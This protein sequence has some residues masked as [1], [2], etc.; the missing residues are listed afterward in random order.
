VP[1]AFVVLEPAAASRAV[2]EPAD[3][4]RLKADIIAFV[5][6][7]KV[8]YKH[9]AGGVEFIDAVPKTPSGKLVRRILRDKATGLRPKSQESLVMKP[10][11]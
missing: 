1:L 9:L 5:A 2:K 3:A 4:K 7:A 6:R 8:N 11:L 10:R